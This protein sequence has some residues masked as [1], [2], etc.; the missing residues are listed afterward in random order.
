MSSDFAFWAG[1]AG[2]P[3]EI[4]DALAEGDTTALE[5]SDAVRRFREVLIERWPDI[6]DVLEPS[7][8]DLD[9]QPEDIA[10]YVLLTLP[11][12][13]LDH[14]PDILAIA[15]EHGLSGYS[16]VADAPIGAAGGRPST[17]T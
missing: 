5:P 16:G 11:V 2:E 3:G 4:F 15:E 12:R 14:L 17:S 7:P 13:F 10:K 8:Y 6:V 1:A 9:E